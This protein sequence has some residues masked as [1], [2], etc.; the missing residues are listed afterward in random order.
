MSK[1]K[2]KNII[3]L[4]VIA[5]LTLSTTSFAAVYDWIGTTDVY[6]DNPDNWEIKSVGS[7]ASQ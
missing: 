3:I 2:S 7:M 5:L 6:W 1:T 4:L